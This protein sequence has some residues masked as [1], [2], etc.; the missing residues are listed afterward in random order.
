M[1]PH[2]TTGGGFAEGRKVQYAGGHALGRA[3]YA[4][5]DLPQQPLFKGAVI[6]AEILGIFRCVHQSKPVLPVLGSRPLDDIAI[7]AGIDVFRKIQPDVLPKQPHGTDVITRAQAHRQI[8]SCILRRRLPPGVQH[9][10]QRVHGPMS[11]GVGRRVGKG[12]GRAGNQ[13]RRVARL[14][15]LQR[16]RPELRR[17]AA[18][19]GVKLAIFVDAA[20]VDAD[21]PFKHVVDTHRNGVE[22]PDGAL[23]PVH[24]GAMSAAANQPHEA[25]RT[26]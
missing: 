10:V 19:E 22:A 20:G 25:S 11:R 4:N 8:R 9:L 13:A 15:M 1:P 5:A 12:E 26:R 14:R 7:R 21:A 24:D 6:H 17:V 16:S 3:Q 23:R 18:G 2:G